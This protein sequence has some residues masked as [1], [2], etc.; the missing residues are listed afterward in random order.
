MAQTV[1][2]PS[3]EGAQ[4]GSKSL[5]DFLAYAKKSGATGAQPSNYMLQAEKGFRSAREIKQ[6]FEKAKMKLDGVS[7][8]CPFWVHTTAW[9]G[10]PS[11]RPFIPVEVA[12]KPPEQIEKWAE[13]YLLGLM[14]LCV[15][16]GVKIVPM[17]WGVAFGW[18]LAGPRHAIRRSADRRPDSGPLR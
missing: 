13:E 5:A 9:T 10:S 7:A 3:V 16:L 8:H 2:H 11:I 1:F 4:H 15:E 12:R 18:E 14:D 17:F 6:I